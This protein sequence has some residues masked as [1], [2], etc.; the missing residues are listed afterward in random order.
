MGLVTVRL[1]LTVH[2][3][4]HRHVAP[5]LGREVAAVPVRPPGFELEPGYPRHEVQFAG[6]DLAVWRPA[7]ARIPAVGQARAEAHVVGDDML[8]KNV[9]AVHQQVTRLAHFNCS[10]VS[11][12]Q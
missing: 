5:G 6:P 2:E 1:T 4:V 11:G 8:A 3:P 10:T 9:I 12:R 7:D